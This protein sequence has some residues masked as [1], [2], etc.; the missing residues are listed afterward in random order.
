MKR[1]CLAASLLLAAAAQ[2]QIRVVN[3][4][5]KSP[6]VTF[7]IVFT[8]GAAADPVNQPGLASLTAMM[9]ADGG[10]KDLTYKQILDARFPMAA[11]FGVQIDK[12][13][14]TFAGATHTDN[15]AAYYKLLRAQLLEPGWREDD[16]ARVKDEAINDIKV[17]LRNNDEE[18]AKEVLYQNIYAGT[19]YGHHNLGTVSSLA[20]ITL[21]DV[22]KFYR[23]HYSQSNLF[24]GLAGGY[25]PAFL[26]G[27]KKDF[28]VLP[29]GGGF[30]PRPKPPALIESNRAVIVDKDT[31]SVA[32]SIGFPISATRATADF[33]ALMV[34]TAFLGQHRMSGGL[35]YDEMREKRGLNY[36]DY[37]Y[38]EYFPQ[39]MYLMEPN[40]NLARHNQIYQLWIRPVEPA[41]AKFALRL[42]L[43]ELEKLRKNGVTE[44]EFERTRDFV[45]KYIN[46]LTRTKRAELGYAIDG[47][48]YGLGNYTER[49]H[50][51]LARLTRDDVNRVIRQHLRSD[52]LV[53]VAV[54]KDGEQL[55]QSLASDDPSPMTY[56]S[57]KPE[58]ITE[59]D[60]IVEKW[61]LHLRAE[62]IQVIPATDVFQ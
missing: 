10:T 11:T 41:T 40:P 22:K 17:G 51:A 33:P 20:A 6:L 12:E 26:E 53:V 57:A 43:Y 56:N 27:M 62:D 7:R 23:T 13:M 28:R 24:L 58:A 5:S 21:D 34:A 30:R 38:A 39:G 4:P 46:I 31:R 1:L 16:F 52:R 47:I 29:Q 15:L 44:E 48:W 3:L 59:E 42:A 61:P 45:S 60:K 50:K 32:I 54:S 19:P 25:S 49:M 37:A 9:L 8:V 35:L 2:A 14:T 18:M 36:G 55:K